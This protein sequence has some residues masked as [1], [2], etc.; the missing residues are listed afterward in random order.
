M[1]GDLVLGVEYWDHRYR[2]GDTPWDLGCVSPPLK[3]YFDQLQ[4]KSVNILIPGAGRAY[5]AIY[6]KI[7]GFK[8][9]SICD[10]SP[11]ATDRIKKKFPEINTI[12]CDFFEL[13]GKFDLI[14]EQTFFCA[15]APNLRR[16][17]FEKMY[18]LLSSHGKIVGLLFASHFD[19]P[20][21][22]FG[23]TKEEYELLFNDLFYAKYIEKSYNSIPP[24]QGNELFFLLKK[25]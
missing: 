17:Y 19:H 21:P 7:L 15:I 18:E 11:T 1:E 4:D 5:E 25:R 3:A 9:V 20:G 2:F 10:I 23:G 6:L 16:K 22:P 8:Q 12:C 13:N 24:R 14:I